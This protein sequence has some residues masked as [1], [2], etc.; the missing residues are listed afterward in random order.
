MQASLTFAHFPEPFKHTITVVLR[1]P[2]KPDYTKATAYR[3]IALESTLGKIMETIVTDIMSYLTETFQLLP[4]QHYGGRSG[5]STEDALMVL[6][7]S[8]HGA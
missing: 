7:E 4:T 5:R 2:S 6:S 1:K 8:I 3:P